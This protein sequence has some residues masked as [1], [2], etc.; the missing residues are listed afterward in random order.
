[1]SRSH[2]CHADSIHSGLFQLGQVQITLR[3]WKI[4]ASIQMDATPLLARHVSGDWGEVGVR[5]KR[6]NNKACQSFAP[7]ESRHRVGGWLLSIATDGQRMT[8]AISLSVE[9]SDLT[10]QG[11]VSAEKEAHTGSGSNWQA[12][13]ASVSRYS[14]RLGDPTGGVG[15]GGA[16]EKAFL[17]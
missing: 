10:V 14:G 12:E 3:A 17:A 1:M 4:L 2:Q 9:I 6:Q 5:R 15:A 13:A 8:T 16:V 7:V 11:G